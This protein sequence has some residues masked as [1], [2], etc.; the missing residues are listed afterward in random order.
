MKKFHFNLITL[1][2]VRCEK[3]KLTQKEFMA[4]QMELDR[5]LEKMALLQQ[6][7]KTLEEEIRTK[8][9][10]GIHPSELSNFLDYLNLIRQ[11]IAEQEDGVMRAKNIVEEKRAALSHAMKERKVIEKLKETKFAQWEKEMQTREKGFLDELA[12][13]RYVRDNS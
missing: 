7:G 3:E 13:M 8:Q 4:A 11:R 2:K 12:T 5:L 10:A 6:E 1:L 9:Q